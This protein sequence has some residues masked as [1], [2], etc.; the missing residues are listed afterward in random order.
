MRKVLKKVIP[1]ILI[2]FLSV[3][4]SF[5][6]DIYSVQATKKYAAF[7]YVK[8][9]FKQASREYERLLYIDSTQK[10]QYKTA[11]LKC[12]YNLQDVNAL[13]S[14]SFTPYDSLTSQF[15]FLLRM[16]QKEFDLA[17]NLLENEDY[18][19]SNEA[20][21]FN[22]GILNLYGLEFE[23]SQEKLSRNFYNNAM[24]VTSAKLQPVITNL[25][26]FKEKKPAIAAL[27]S[28]A[29][30]SLGRVYT[31]DYADAALNFLLISVTAFQAYR[32][33]SNKDIGEWQGWVY[34]SL[35]ASFYLGN[36]F[37]SYKAAKR[38]NNNF[39]NGE[40]DKADT[41]IFSNY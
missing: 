41:Y 28:T 38:Y 18:T 26:N 30:P 17:Q 31:N 9:D 40:L 35:S 21:T 15:V 27:L 7:L 16:R 29:V 4:G 36:I 25:I 37:G 20:E 6:Q 33:F 2:A 10:K 22:S 12:Y 11:L 14:L 24:S 32:G 5:G 8:G 3:H 19:Y 1:L 23:Q 34:G 13:K 39:Y